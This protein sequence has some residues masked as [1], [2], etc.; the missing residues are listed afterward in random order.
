[1]MESNVDSTDV[2]CAIGKSFKELFIESLKNQL[3]NDETKYNEFFQTLNE[4]KNFTYIFEM[5]HPLT[6]VVIEYDKPD[7]RHIGTRNNDT[8]EELD[9]N[10][11]IQ[12]PIEYKFNS[13]ED[14]VNMSRILPYS[15][16]GYVV[17][18]A[19]WN[20]VKV[21][22]PAYLAVHHLENNGVLSARRVMDII[23]NGEQSEVLANFPEFTDYFNVAS[24]VFYNF[25]SELQKNIDDFRN[26]T[27]ETKK[28]FAMVV[29]KTQFPSFFFQVYDGKYTYDDLSKYLH[30]YGGEK[31]AKIL[32]IKDKLLKI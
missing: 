26:M 2:T 9:I 8:Y 22:S 19:N 27:F 29:S 24:E 32:K 23:L 25:K 1:M 12:K 4:H 17:V 30:E 3:D 13:F 15:E 10:I 21:K 7:I 5:V 16:E 28:D 18:D 20:R 11:G 31:I 6:R 14:V